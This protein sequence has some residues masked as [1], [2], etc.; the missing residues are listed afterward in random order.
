MFAKLFGPSHDQ[1][2]VTLMRDAIDVP[3]ICVH[4]EHGSFVDAMALDYEPGEAGWATA[5]G[6]FERMDEAEARRGIAAALRS[7][8]PGVWHILRE[9]PTFLDEL[10]VDA[11][12]PTY[13]CFRR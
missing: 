6:A 10:P 13:V 4:Y 9:S 8:Q 12:M 7:E 1:V 3:Q 5:C 2:L 11:P